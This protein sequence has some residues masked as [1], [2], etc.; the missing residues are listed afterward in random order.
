MTSMLRTSDRF[1]A[2][3]RE[4]SLYGHAEGSGRSNPEDVMK[5][6]IERFG[7]EATM[8]AVKRAKELGFGIRAVA[9]E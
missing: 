6:A 8:K 2:I 4:K 7:E 5:E 3:I 9:G 1:H